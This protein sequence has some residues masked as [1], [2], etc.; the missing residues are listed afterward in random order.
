MKAIRLKKSSGAGVVLMM[1]A[2]GLWATMYKHPSF[3][4]NWTVLI[5]AI[6][7]CVGMMLIKTEGK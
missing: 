7:A 1:I 3:A 2:F 5:A 6:S 4:N